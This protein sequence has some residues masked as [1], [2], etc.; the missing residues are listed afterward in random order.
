MAFAVLPGIISFSKAIIY[1]VLLVA[2]GLICS[3]VY[4][5]LPWLIPGQIWSNITSWRKQIP[6]TTWTIP[7]TWLK[8]SLD[9]RGFWIQKVFH[10][11]QR[12]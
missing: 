1:A 11:S 4:P 9:W 12:S 6:P 5:L 8:T 7:S 10:S 3:Q 2:P